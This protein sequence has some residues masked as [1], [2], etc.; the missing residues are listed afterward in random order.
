[1]QVG[2]LTYGYIYAVAQRFKVQSDKAILEGDH[3]FSFEFNPTD[4]AE[5]AK[6]KGVPASVTLLVDGARLGERVRESTL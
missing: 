6:G 5:I 4:K 1:V 2:K 3:I